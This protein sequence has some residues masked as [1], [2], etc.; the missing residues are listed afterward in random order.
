MKGIICS[1]LVGGDGRGGTAG[2]DDRHD[3]ENGYC[4]D[5][6]D[7]DKDYSDITLMVIVMMIMLL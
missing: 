3:G 7:D 1:Y 2:E 5:L 6:H 4:V